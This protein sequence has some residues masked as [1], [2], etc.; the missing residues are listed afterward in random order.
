MPIIFNNEKTKVKSQRMKKWRDK[1]K[2]NYNKKMRDWRAKNK[3]HYNKYSR[4]LRKWNN[5]K[6]VFLNILL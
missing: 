2:E 1:N 3:E 4:D 5:I 6:K